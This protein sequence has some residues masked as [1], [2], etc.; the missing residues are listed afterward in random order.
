MNLFSGEAPVNMAGSG[1]Q[2]GVSVSL[3]QPVEPVWIWDS[4]QHIKY[5][6]KTAVDMRK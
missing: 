1:N 2:N 6:R 5:M 4:T 3:R